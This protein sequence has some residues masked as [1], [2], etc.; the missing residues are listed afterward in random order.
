MDRVIGMYCAGHIR[1]Q[2]IAVCVFYCQA[3]RR[4]WY[5]RS[6]VGLRRPTPPQRE[7]EVQAEE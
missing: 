4:G 6:T 7:P 2:L 3:L 1:S 5:I